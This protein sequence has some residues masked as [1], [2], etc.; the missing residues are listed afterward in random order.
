M[1]CPAVCPFCAGENDACALVCNA[2]HRDIVIP[3]SLI[4]EHQELLHKR[5][6]LR[7]ELDQTRAAISRRRKPV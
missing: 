1:T 4:A 3:S 2:C 5:E 6:Q 7:A